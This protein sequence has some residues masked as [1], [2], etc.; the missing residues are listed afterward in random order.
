MQGRRISAALFRLH[1]RVHAQTADGAGS[2]AEPAHR[3]R[4]GITVSK[5]VAPL[6]VQRN[7]IKRIVRESFR[8]HRAQ[9]PP[10]DYV[11][12]AQPA[13]TAAP[14]AAMRAEL[15]SL[16]R[17]AGVLKPGPAVPTMPARADTG[18]ASP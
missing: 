10:G 14:P 5:R 9:M 18:D 3:A 17:R 7:R 1:A 2:E 12:Q 4:L 15:S 13:A 16:W 11:V 6:A 8:G